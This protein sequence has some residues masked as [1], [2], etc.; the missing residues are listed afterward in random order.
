M[1]VSCS[2]C[3][4]KQIDLILRTEDA[5]KAAKPKPTAKSKRR[6]G[7][8]DLSCLLGIHQGI[9]TYLPVFFFHGMMSSFEYS[10][11]L[12]DIVYTI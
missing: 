4:E 8:S 11:M 7:G 10:I 6:K 9:G 12:I 1:V 3:R 5:K 2:C